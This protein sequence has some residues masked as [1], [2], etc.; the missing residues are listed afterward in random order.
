MRM[1][2]S[3]AFYFSGVIVEH[4]I[5]PT[6]SS[7]SYNVAAV[8]P[9]AGP[10]NAFADNNGNKA[11]FQVSADGTSIQFTI[12]GPVSG[13]GWISLAF[14]ADQLMVG[15]LDWLVGICKMFIGWL[16]GRSLSGLLSARLVCYL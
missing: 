11:A 1:P 6:V 14:S 8:P 10:S 2:S 15:L 5:F 4:N 9:T 16:A 3:F 13:S 12:S 7:T